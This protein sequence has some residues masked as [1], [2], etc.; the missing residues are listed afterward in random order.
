EITSFSWFKTLLRDLEDIQ[1]DYSF[2]RMDM[3]L[4]GSVDEDTI[5]NVVLNMGEHKC[6]SLTGL[7]SQTHFGKPHWKKDIFDP[8][9]KAISSGDWYEREISGTTKV[10]CFYCGPRPLA[11]TLGKRMSRSYHR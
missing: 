3:Y 1:H 9:R 4:T 10:G 5:S 8:I 11:K 2:L 6:D 7:K